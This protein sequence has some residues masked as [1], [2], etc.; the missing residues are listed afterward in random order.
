MT[1][2]DNNH[3]AKLQ[4]EDALKDKTIPVKK[5]HITVPEE[6]LNE[7]EINADGEVIDSGNN[8]TAAKNDH[9]NNATL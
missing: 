3:K 7:D 8:Y 4:N 9:D 2:A 5:E 1:N 6:E